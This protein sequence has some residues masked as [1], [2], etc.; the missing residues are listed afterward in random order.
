MPLALCVGNSGQGFQPK[1]RGGKDMSKS[2][3]N[4]DVYR[5]KEIEIERSL[6]STLLKVSEIYRVY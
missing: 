2:Q 1:P 3:A 6:M 5:F 4:G